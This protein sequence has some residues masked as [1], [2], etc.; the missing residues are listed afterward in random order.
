MPMDSDADLR[1]QALLLV[2]G[3]EG[4][5]AVLALGLGWLLGQPALET[6]HWSMDAV[7]V[8]AAASVPMLALFLCIE[9][10]PVGPLQR[11][12][13]YLDETIRPLFGPCSLVELAVFSFLAGLG[14]EMLFRGVIQA[15]TARWLGL[16]P[17]LLIASAL[18]G[19][20]HPI[21]RT[22][23]VLAAALGAYL[24]GVWLLSGNLL[25]VIVTHAVY[26][27]VVLVYLLRRRRT[28][29]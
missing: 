4:G 6:F 28:S 22:Y 9:R 27:F 2:V 11:I 3:F 1:W 16:W 14:E 29:V 18:F 15:A 23:I 12:R 24:G 8:G 21:T 25:T 17:G 19:L 26:D 7:A 20:L 5:L 13:R 10:W